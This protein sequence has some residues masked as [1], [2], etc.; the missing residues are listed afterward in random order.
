MSEMTNAGAYSAFCSTTAVTV[1]RTKCTTNDWQQVLAKWQGDCELYVPCCEKSEVYVT[2][3]QWQLAHLLIVSSCCQFTEV[4]VMSK[5]CVSQTCFS[6]FLLDFYTDELINIRVRVNGISCMPSTLS[7]FYCV[8][9]RR[10]EPAKLS[11]LRRFW[12]DFWLFKMFFIIQPTDDNI[13]L[14][15][16]SAFALVKASEWVSSFLTAHQHN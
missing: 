2:S 13:P 1:C 10:L 7:V 12:W 16:L 5:S 8:S 6:I 11:S 14:N 15:S 3:V 4:E 9:I